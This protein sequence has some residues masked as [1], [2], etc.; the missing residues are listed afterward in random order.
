MIPVKFEKLRNDA[1]PPKKMYESDACF[2][3]YTP[4]AFDIGPNE[5]KMVFLG[6]RT[7]IPEGFEVQIRSRGSLAL[8]G[9]TVHNAPGTIDAGFRGEWG[10]M[11]HNNDDCTRGFKRGDRIAQCCLRIVLNWYLE[12]TKDGIEI[13]DSYDERGEAGFGSTGL[14]IAN[15][16]D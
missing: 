9:I 15:T 6:F 11:L 13:S 2:D 8:G 3:I 1:Y 7:E 14:H 4:D 16:K 12:E 5:T 10:I